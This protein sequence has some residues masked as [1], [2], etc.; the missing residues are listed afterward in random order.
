MAVLWMVDKTQ[1]HKHYSM[2]NLPHHKFASFFPGDIWHSLGIH[3]EKMK[4]KNERHFEKWR[5][6]FCFSN[7]P[8]KRWSKN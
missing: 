3:R 5:E 8:P 6:H 2:S 1:G 4:Q 7:I